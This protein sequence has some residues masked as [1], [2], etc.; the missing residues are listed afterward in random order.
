MLHTKLLC[1]YSFD[2]VYQY[3]KKDYYPIGEC[4]AVCR[5]EKNE[6]GVAELLKRNGNYLEGLETYLKIINGLDIVEMGKELHK[7]Q[8]TKSKY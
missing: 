6:R 8:P 2:E 4:L 5:E 1:K 3:V 7:S